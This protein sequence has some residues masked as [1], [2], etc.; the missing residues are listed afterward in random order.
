[1]QPRSDTSSSTSFAADQLFY[2]RPGTEY[3]RAANLATYAVIGGNRPILAVLSSSFHAV[4][5]LKR[6]PSSLSIAG[7]GSFNPVIFAEHMSA[8]SW[9][10]IRPTKL[11]EETEQFKTII[12]AEPK[13]DT[14][15]LTLRNIKFLAKHGS[16]LQII[17]SSGIKW[18]FPKTGGRNATKPRSGDS[19]LLPNGM[20]NLLRMRGWKVDGVV[21]FLGPRAAFW[22]ALG[23]NFQRVNMLYWSDRCFQ[24]MRSQLREPGWLWPLA[25]LALIR[26]R[27]D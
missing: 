3:V 19:P 16:D 9:G 27:L 7:T 5:I 2:S 8:W 14:A 11:E 6:S 13:R 4:E 18:L 15:D 10:D 20:V 21:P 12:W 26:A 22:K 24:T 1:M 23:E 17:T 25:P